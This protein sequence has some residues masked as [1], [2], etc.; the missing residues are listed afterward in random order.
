MYAFLINFLAFVESAKFQLTEQNTAGSARK[1]IH[2]IDKLS[3]NGTSSVGSWNRL[4][5]VNNVYMR[6]I[7]TNNRYW[8][9]EY[10]YC[11]L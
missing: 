4:I 8:I 10:I 2:V 3:F 6:K 5:S 7:A 11:T 9:W 1:S